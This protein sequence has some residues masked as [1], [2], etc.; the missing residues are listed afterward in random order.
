MYDGD[1]SK[2]AYVPT[3]DALNAQGM[4]VGFGNTQNNVYNITP[5]SAEASPAT[6]EPSSEDN[7]T[8]AGKGVGV[9]AF[10]IL[11]VILGCYNMIKDSPEPKPSFPSENGQ[12]PEGSN[13]QAVL[14]AA[15]DA[16]RSCVKAPVLKPVHCPQQINDF[17]ADNAAD[18]AW[19]LHGDPSDGARVVFNGEE[20]RFHVLGTAVMTVSY[21]EAPNQP[22]FRLRIVHYWARIEWTN[23]QPR[24]AEI[25]AYDDSPRPETNKRNPYVPDDV[26]FPL[27]EQAFQ[28]CAAAKSSPMTPECPAS[29][30]PIQSNKAEW[31]LN[32]SPLVNAHATFDS[33]SGLIHVT[34]NYSITVVYKLWLSGTTSQTETGQYD[35]VLSVDDGKPVVLRI[36]KP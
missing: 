28:T 20:G 22:R 23:N 10:V 2:P 6:D 26:A 29:K 17:N 32:G 33:P 11:L 8:T 15:L 5:A 1:L 12:R 36:Q 19:R 34:G 24:L 25:R 9:A 30:N 3:V 13:D 18:V 31:K 7:Q 14:G 21:K 4:Q 16:L 27:V 35:A